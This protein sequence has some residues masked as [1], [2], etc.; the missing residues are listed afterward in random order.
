MRRRIL[1]TCLLAYPRD[2]RERDGA[3]LCDLAEDLAAEHGIVREAVGLVR[4]GWSE[5]VRRW[6][7][8]RGATV[9]T[10]TTGAVV[11]VLTW[12]AAAAAQPGRVEEDRF[13]CAGDCALM[14][15]EVAQRT[16]RGWTCVEL[17]PADAATWQCTL[18]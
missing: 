16:A 9:A 3:E 6:S 15:R 18:D 14:E 7:P 13:E 4:G 17:H 2:L 12:S 11:A 8:R 5:R 1:R 10:V